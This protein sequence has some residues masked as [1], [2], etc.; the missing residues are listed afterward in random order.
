M[1]MKVSSV[2]MNPREVAIFNIV[3]KDYE[4]G[5]RKVSMAAVVREGLEILA[6]EKGFSEAEIRKAAS[7]YR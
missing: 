1:N 7:R 4:A 5:G 3:R 6:K 2:R